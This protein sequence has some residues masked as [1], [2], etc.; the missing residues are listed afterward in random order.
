MRPTYS[1][2]CPLQNCKKFLGAWVSVEAAMSRVLEHL[3]SAHGSRPIAV[4]GL[5]TP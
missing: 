3:D 1:A 2:K 5:E 4:V